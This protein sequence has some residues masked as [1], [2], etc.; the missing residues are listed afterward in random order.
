MNK[1]IQK[2]ISKFQN[3]RYDSC[4]K[5]FFFHLLLPK[6]LQELY[7]TKQPEVE[8]L[9]DIVIDDIVKAMDNELQRP[10]SIEVLLML[11]ID[12]HDKSQIFFWSQNSSI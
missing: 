6:D 7:E 2:D 5:M 10:E 3:E 4:R 12:N 8:M 9:I 1:K 11:T